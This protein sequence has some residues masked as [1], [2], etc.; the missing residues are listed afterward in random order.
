MKRYAL[1]EVDGKYFAPQGTMEPYQ[2]STTG[3]TGE[4]M[5]RAAALIKLAK[6]AG[7]PGL[8]YDDFWWLRD[9]EEARDAL[10]AAWPTWDEE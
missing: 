1:V 9:L 6:A 5:D 4:Q 8:P 10:R 7:D 2:F 3:V